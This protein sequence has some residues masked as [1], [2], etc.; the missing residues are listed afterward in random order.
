M[1]EE[2]AVFWGMGLHGVV[3]CFASRNSDGIVTHI[4]HQ[5]RTSDTTTRDGVTCWAS[6]ESHEQEVLRES[7]THTT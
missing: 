5:L 6:V 7:K 1:L 4:L 2:P 3:V